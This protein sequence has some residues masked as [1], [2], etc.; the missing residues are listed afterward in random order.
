MVAPALRE[1]LQCS[2]LV[3]ECT[4][5]DVCTGRA[6]HGVCGDVVQLS[7]RCRADELLEVRWRAQ[8]C[9]ATLAV[10]ALAARTWTLLPLAQ[11]ATALQAALDGHGGLAVHERHAAALVLR[12]LAAATGR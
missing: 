9:P 8:G 5:L 11:A 7:V 6:E 2:D 1:L 4:G 10:A 3:G 12:A